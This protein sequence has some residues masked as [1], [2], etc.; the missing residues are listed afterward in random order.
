VVYF[1]AK[2]ENKPLTLVIMRAKQPPLA[3]YI[4]YATLVALLSRSQRGEA[5]RPMLRIPR[6]VPK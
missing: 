6:I 4:G 5:K 1:R 3:L 2:P